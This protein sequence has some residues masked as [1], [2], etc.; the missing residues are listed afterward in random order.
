MDLVLS[1]DAGQTGYERMVGLAPRL[2]PAKTRQLFAEGKQGVQLKPESV[3]KFRLKS[4]GS[5]LLEN[6]SNDRT[7]PL[8]VC[9]GN[10]PSQAVRTRA[11]YSRQWRLVG[12]G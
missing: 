1:D 11:N 12:V 6:A 3:R 9:H 2:E 4:R 7:Q 5:L 10:L 8:R